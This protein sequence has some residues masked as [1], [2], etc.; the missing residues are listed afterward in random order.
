MFQ[1]LDTLLDFVAPRGLTH[2]GGDPAAEAA[3]GMAAELRREVAAAR[4]GD[5]ADLP[6]AAPDDA[7]DG[8]PEDAAAAVG[9][10]E[11]RD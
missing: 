10:R 2:A 9:P 6:E 8:L 5:D 3:G 1:E 4:F 11:E 7:P